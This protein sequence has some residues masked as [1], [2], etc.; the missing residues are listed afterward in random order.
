MSFRTLL[1][2]HVDDDAE[3]R[4]LIALCLATAEDMTLTS[5]DSGPAALEHLKAAP[6]PHLIL[7]DV[8]MPEMDGPA[9][10]AA[11]RGLDGLAET[12]VVFLTGRTAEHEC[13]RY[14]ALG[15]ADVIAKPFDPARLA[16]DIRRH[17]A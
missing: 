10:L 12:P 7:L 11:L 14:R 4:D 3:M 15:A 16:D 1:I 2:L 5:L 17:A 6:P 9:T 8:C 13:A